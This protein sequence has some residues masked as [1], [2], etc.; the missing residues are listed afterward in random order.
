MTRLEPFW[1]DSTCGLGIRESG[2]PYLFIRGTRF[3]QVGVI[4]ARFA[5][6][7]AAD[8]ATRFYIFKAFSL[9][10]DEPLGRHDD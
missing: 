1:L 5:A 8:F 6:Q 9:T 3:F 2:S 7:F 10:Y 4:R